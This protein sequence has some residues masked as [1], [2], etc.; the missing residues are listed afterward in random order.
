MR[1]NMIASAYGGSELTGVSSGLGNRDDHLVFG[2]FRPIRGGTG[3]HEHRCVRHYHA[4][5]ES[6]AP[7]FVI[8][9]TPDVSGIREP[10]SRS[11]AATLVAAG[12]RRPRT[13]WRADLA[14][15]T[16]GHVDLAKLGTL[17]AGKVVMMEGGPTLAGAMVSLGLIDEMFLTIAPV[18]IAGGSG[19]VVHGLD[20]GSDALGPCARLRRR[21]GLPVPSLRPTERA[22]R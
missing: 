21:A 4:P 5:D 12:R 8:A 22:G 9:K 18:W 14:A 15:G 16:G 11:D 20:H 19:R 6:G 13:G 2:A 1:L 3:R 17:L 10:C 7:I